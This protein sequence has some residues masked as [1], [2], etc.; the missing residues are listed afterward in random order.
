M[1]ANVPEQ[2]LFRQPEELRDHRVDEVG[3]QSHHFQSAGAVAVGGRDLGALLLDELLDARE[4][5][6]S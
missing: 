3:V 6:V 5:S 2:Q 1:V 4:E